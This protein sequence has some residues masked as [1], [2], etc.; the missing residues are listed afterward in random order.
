M[1]QIAPFKKSYLGSMPLNPLAMLCGMQ[2][3]EPEKK[4]CP[5]AKSW[6]RLSD[7]RWINNKKY[8]NYHKNNYYN[9]SFRRTLDYNHCMCSGYLLNTATASSHIIHHYENKRTVEYLKL[10][11][12][13]TF[14]CSR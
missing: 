2:V 11:F 10:S 4:S 3:S 14:L 5:P 6:L 12:E 1:H 13:T 7:Y 9:H 8:V